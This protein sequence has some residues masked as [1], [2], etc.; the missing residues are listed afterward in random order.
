MM[1]MTV[2]AVTLAL[3]LVGQSPASCSQPS[4]ELKELVRKDVLSFGYECRD[5][6]YACM[7]VDETTMQVMCDGRPYVLAGPKGIGGR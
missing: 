6:T 1:T 4:E 3:T 7:S 5:V 2:K